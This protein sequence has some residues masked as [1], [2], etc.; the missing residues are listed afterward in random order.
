MNEDT[1]RQA[2]EENK[3]GKNLV[4]ERQQNELEVSINTKRN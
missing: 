1:K 2:R 3:N 4:K